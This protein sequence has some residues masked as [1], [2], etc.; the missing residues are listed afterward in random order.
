MVPGNSTVKVDSE[1]TIDQSI[2]YIITA[3]P[4]YNSYN[5]TYEFEYWTDATEKYPFYF[6]FY[7]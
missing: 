3:V 5:T 6:T 2:S 7:H 1:F 4:K